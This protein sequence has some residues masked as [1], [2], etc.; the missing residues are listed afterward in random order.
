MN[1]FPDIQTDLL[2][3][4]TA[5][6]E[7]TESE[8][9]ADAGAGHGDTHTATTEQPVPLAPQVTGVLEPISGAQTMVLSLFGVLAFFMLL[10]ITR[11][12]RKHDYG[13]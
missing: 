3:S 12:G 10:A 8:A 11:Y 5:P 7:T 13:D 2:F 6:A 9:P 4:E 1:R